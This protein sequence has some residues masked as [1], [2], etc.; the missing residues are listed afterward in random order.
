MT[1]LGCSKT[2]LEVRIRHCD[3]V[4]DR[5][6]RYFNR[7]QR[8]AKERHSDLSFQDII[9]AIV[10]RTETDHEKYDAMINTFEEQELT[11]VHNTGR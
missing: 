6:A 8:L 10:E 1:G 3:I 7:C 9:A 4:I 2:P 5:K 11:E